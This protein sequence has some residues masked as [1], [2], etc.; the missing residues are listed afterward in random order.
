MKGH[1]RSA[2]GVPL[3]VAFLYA[4]FAFRGPGAAIVGITDPT[5]SG[6]L[7]SALLQEALLGVAISTCMAVGLFVATWRVTPAPERR[8]E[9]AV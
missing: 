7:D 4:W 5:Q 6:D 2:H 3:A 1:R 9:V 8:E